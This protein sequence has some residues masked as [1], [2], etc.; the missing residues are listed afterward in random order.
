MPFALPERQMVPQKAYCWPLVQRQRGFGPELLRQ[1]RHRGF[2]SVEL[3]AAEELILKQ[4][5]VAFERKRS[6]RYPPIPGAKLPCY[7]ML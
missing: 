6:F 3:T 4:A 5:L 7:S 2:L 1:L